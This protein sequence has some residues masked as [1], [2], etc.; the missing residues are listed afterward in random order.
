MAS[1][2][3]QF[4][5]VHE[6]LQWTLSV[7]VD[8]FKLAGPKRYLK[9]GWALIRK[10]I[11]MEDPTRMQL[12][13]G[14]IHKRFEGNINGKGP[15]V[16]I[17]YGMESC[18]ASSVQRHV[19][20]CGPSSAQT[21]AIALSEELSKRNPWSSKSKDWNSKFRKIIAYFSRWSRGNSCSRT[22][23]WIIRAKR[24]NQSRDHRWGDQTGKSNRQNQNRDLRRWEEWRIE[25]WWSTRGSHQLIDGRLLQRTWACYLWD[26]LGEYNA[27]FRIFQWFPEK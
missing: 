11:Q 8:D 6:A 7:Y 3:W 22:N 5:F 15:V 10:H 19:K 12:Y 16:G 13:L 14:C 17:E 20:L 4:L 23:S 27:S 25:K 21:G 1:K 2:V 24:R 18:L 9:Q 26:K